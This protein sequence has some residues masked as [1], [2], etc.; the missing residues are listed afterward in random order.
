MSLTSTYLAHVASPTAP[1]NCPNQT[2]SSEGNAHCSNRL[3]LRSCLMAAPMPSPLTWLPRLNNKAYRRSPSPLSGGPGGEIE[4]T[5]LHPNLT[6]HSQPHL[7]HL[8]RKVVSKLSVKS[9]WCSQISP[10]ANADALT[11][12][13]SNQQGRGEVQSLREL[14]ASLERVL[15]VVCCV[16][17]VWCVSAMTRRDSFD[18]QQDSLFFLDRCQI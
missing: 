2:S 6:G 13:F 5:E 11:P 14:G 4:R 10:G 15:C 7:L 8:L 17:C 1:L 3:L 18:E 9:C 16:F 12:H